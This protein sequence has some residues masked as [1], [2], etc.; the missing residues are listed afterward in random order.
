MGE[1]VYE[2]LW[3]RANNVNR[4]LYAVPSSAQTARD[5]RME[6]LIQSTTAA[7]SSSSSTSSSKQRKS[8][9]SGK[10]KLRY[11]RSVSQ[12]DDAQVPV[13]V[14]VTRDSSDSTAAAAASTDVTS[15]NS[16]LSDGI[17]AS[18]QTDTDTD[19][20][21][22]MDSVRGR[23]LPETPSQNG[24]V[25]PPAKLAQR[26][27]SVQSNVL[28]TRVSV[29]H[30]TPSAS[31]Q[32]IHLSAD[33]KPDA[34]YGNTEPVTNP[35]TDSLVT[36]G[37]S[38][39]EYT[40]AVSTN[41]KHRPES[42]VLDVNQNV[43]KPVTDTTSTQS[44]A[45]N[46]QVY[47]NVRS[48]QNG[49]SSLS[50]VDKSLDETDNERNEAILHLL[51]AGGVA[52][53]EPTTHNAAAIT[54]ESLSQ[55]SSTTQSAVDTTSASTEAASGGE[56]CTDGLPPDIS[57]GVVLQRG[58]NQ[59]LKETQVQEIEKQQRCSGG[60]KLVLSRAD[61]HQTVAFI[62]CFGSFW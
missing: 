34:I 58:A 44:H 54:A 56:D 62:E 48:T 50:A 11:R 1:E 42:S 9:R 13:S 57:P 7:Q 35:D 47:F 30:D 31:N 22:R 55:S 25:I 60:V 6:E 38:T 14:D 29:V 33:S 24:D 4:D 41:Q 53:A 27:I 49:V 51:A 20:K 36:S 61:C 39:D 40:D 43:N 45:D 59:S 32:C 46:E 3:E 23:P 15:L 21:S 17:G 16:T 2:T 12:D 28:A 10:A 19:V 52:A 37:I 5:A 26:S 18:P 8:S